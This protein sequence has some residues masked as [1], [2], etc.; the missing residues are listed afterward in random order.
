MAR[1]KLPKLEIKK[2]SGKIQEWSEFW[3]SYNS[4]IHTEQGLAKVDKFKYLR[5]FLEEPVRRVIAGLALTGENYDAAIEILTDRFAKPMKIKRAHINDI[6]TL[7]PV[8]NERNATR[9]RHL[10]DEIEAHF[11]SLEALGADKDSYSSVVV[12]VVMEKIPESVRI[13][14]I[15]SDGDFLDWNLEDLLKALAK[16]VEIREINI[17]LQSQQQ[18]VDRRPNPGRHS[19][20]AGTASALFA[21]R[22]NDRK[23]NCPFCQEEHYAEDCSRY[24]NP[25]ERKHILSKYARC[26]LCLNKGHRSFDCRSKSRCK[27]CKGKHHFLIC[28][29]RPI[30]SNFETKEAAQPSNAG[31]AAQPSNA[32]TAAQPGNASATLLNPNATS[33]VGSTGTSPPPPDERGVA[34]QTAL[35]RVGD[36]K[37][38]KVRVLFDSGSQKTFISAKAVDRLALKPLREECLGIKTFG[39]SEPE[40]KKRSVYELSLEPLRNDDRNVRV[41]AF[42]V[43]DICTISNIHVEEVKRNYKHLRDI[44]FSD[45]S[46]AEDLLEID[47]LV[48]SNYL[49]C[50]QDGKFIRGGQEE[51]VAIKTSLGWVLSG[52]VKG[53]HFNSNSESCVALAID[54][55]PLSS[56][57]LLNLNKSVHKL[58]DLDTLGIRNNDADN[59]VHQRVIDGVTFNG[60]R[61]SVGLPWKAGH[62]PIPSNYNSS[63][64]RLKS[65][66]SKLRATP[67]VLEQYN[68][69]IM[70]QLDSGIIELVPE[71]DTATKVSYLPH[72]P[73][74]R[75]QAETTKV[76]VVYDASC[77]DRATKISLNDCLHVGPALNPLMFDILVRFR[78]NPVVLISDIEKAFLNI[79][80]HDEDRDCLRFLWVRDIDATNLEVM[81]YR[82][83]RVVFGVNS[84]P[85]LLNAVLRY[86]LDKYKATDPQFVDCLKRSFFV[87]DLVT[88]CRNSEEAYLLYEKAKMRMLEGGFKLRKWKTNVDKLS[89]KICD[90]ESGGESDERD[91]MKTEPNSP[92]DNITKVLGL[93]WDKEAD[94]LQFK[95]DKLV[96]DSNMIVPT[97]RVILST[98][99]TLF[100]PLGLISPLVVP[101]KVLFQD[102]CLSKLDWDEPLPPNELSRWEEW[103]K[104]LKQVRTIA[105]PRS[106][107]RGLKGEVIKTSLHGYGDASGKAYCATIYIVH[108]TTEGVY[109]TLV[110]SKTR[111]APLKQLSIPRL[112][113]MA[114]KI[115]TTL[116]NTVVNALSPHAKISE[117]RYWTDS[118]TV[119]YWIQNRGEWK[120]FV[121]HRVREIL[122]LTEKSQWGHVSGLENP[123]DLGSRGVTA[124]QLC[125]SRLWWEGPQWL[126]GSPS[127]WPSDTLEGEPIEVKTERKKE[128]VLVTTAEEPLL[129]SQVVDIS[130]YS[131]LGKLLRVTAYV[132][133]FVNNLKKRLAKEEI[134]VG[135]LSIDEIERAEIEWIKCAQKRLQE[136]SDYKKYKDQLGIVNENGILVCKGRLEF[137]ELEM[138]TKNPIILPK[139]D[140]FTEL[141]IMDCHRKVHHCKV[142]AT[143]AELRTRFWVTKGRQY[144]KKLLSSCF[145]C[146]K[147][148]GKPFNPP[149]VA[150]LPDFR[151]NEAPPFSKI[152][153]DFAGPLYCKGT[154]GSKMKTYIVLFTCCITR[155]IHLELATDLSAPT[156]LNALRRLSSRRGTPSL[157]V[158][159]NAKTFKSTAKLLTNIFSDKEIADYM[160]NHR[161]RWMFNLPRCPWSGG[162]FERM[163]RSVKECLRKVLGNARLTHDELHTVLTEIECTLNSRPITYQYDIGEVL[164]PSHLILGQRLSPFSSKISPNADVLV[165]NAK[166]SKRF[167]FLKKKL[168]HFWSR[169]KKEY[170]VNLREYHRMNKHTPNIVEKGE[171]VLVHEDGA[172][173]LTWKMGVIK[174]LITGRDG[175][176]RGVTIQVICKGKPLILRRPIQRVYP[177]EISNTVRDSR[178]DENVE[179]GDGQVGMNK[180]GVVDNEEKNGTEEVRGGNPRPARAAAANASC[181]NK[182]LLDP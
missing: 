161:I 58:W 132:K 93:T 105:A 110:C 166:L 143:L 133:R 7:P 24:D 106:M 27:F 35:A 47:I 55:S 81:A 83:K 16:E 50:F 114:A 40:I 54:P 71:E 15:R 180:N 46:K 86:H 44:Y 172:K 119:L 75:E 69:I 136:N 137:S 116:M 11:R 128:V 162:I 51:P 157:V 174:D 73:V 159:D 94:S 127:S 115:L 88:S 130:R 4:A 113:L 156:F 134:A 90:K 63:L 70:E 52:P 2:F 150:P 168:S 34:L 139:N 170:L 99:A 91:Q 76:R 68:A 60:Q 23:K 57:E 146:R 33:W 148:D 65:Q 140:R 181:K 8:F 142:L 163:V 112:E 10:Y 108:E 97:K 1:V 38:S 147:L 42:L 77:K 89:Q 167:L 45:V 28:S 164:T 92:P 26:F 6:M 20:K 14:M 169:W 151:T 122:E 175:E 121:Q 126:R 179:M 13:S 64:V 100:D 102:L 177:L 158:S 129:I 59:D 30:S 5:G 32:G 66:I 101:A 135:R 117:V 43:D 19:E 131:T 152:G 171:V 39:Q 125:D 160:E 149:N 78:E 141:I 17:P 48:G 82:F 3:D 144:V 165:T 22:H 36:K 85:F 29:S 74:V 145:V 178:I 104:S 12:P 155:G 111:I 120:V 21:G 118:M 53:K 123:A 61:Y 9:L 176:I 153:V 62:G 80:V 182:L 124:S 98:L 72:Q 41:E 109:S 31:T 84:S 18:R 96:E 87:D 103:I 25:E 67:D 154:R 56:H 138:S 37:E 79:E 173:K 95:F 49:W 107:Q